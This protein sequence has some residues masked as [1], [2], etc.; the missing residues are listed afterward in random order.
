[1][2]EIGMLRTAPKA[3]ASIRGP[4]RQNLGYR[5]VGARTFHCATPDAGMRLQRYAH[6]A[7]GSDRG[8]ARALFDSA[9]EAVDVSTL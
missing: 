5:P 7:G 2:T 4:V 6:H 3:I 1:M 8:N 9:E